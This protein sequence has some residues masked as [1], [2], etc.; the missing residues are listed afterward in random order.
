MAERKRKLKFSE[1]EL[2]VLTNEVQRHAA[3]LQSRNLT[4]SERNHIWESVAERVS[5]VGQCKHMA[6][7]CKRR[8]VDLKR[9]TKEKVAFNS[10]QAAATGGGPPIEDPLTEIE[11]EVQQTLQKEQVHGLDGIDTAEPMPQ[12]IED[13]LMSGPSCTGAASNQDDSP[14]RLTPS[15]PEPRETPV[16]PPPSVPINYADIDR[17]LYLE[18]QKQTTAQMQYAS[19]L[20]EIESE[21]RGAA[22]SSQQVVSDLAGLNINISSWR[23]QMQANHIELLGALGRIA[24]ALEAKN[25]PSA[26]RVMSDMLRRQLRERKGK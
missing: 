20:S 11:E 12:D 25:E 3:K 19:T 22:S 5:A 10:R 9:R 1:T 18:Q 26:S 13:C 15:T 23:S 24:D 4:P 2:H 21:I 17:L 8:W 14:S 6:D 7:D 16:I